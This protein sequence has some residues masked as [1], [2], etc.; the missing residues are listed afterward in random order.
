MPRFTTTV[1]G[2]VLN[3]PWLLLILSSS[4]GSICG[5][6][7]LLLGLRLIRGL[8][9]TI[10]GLIVMMK[11]LSQ[12][13]WDTSR[14]SAPRIDRA[15]KQKYVRCQLCQ[16][17]AP[18]SNV[19]L[20]PCLKLLSHHVID[21]IQVSEFV[22]LMAGTEKDTRV[23]DMERAREDIKRWGKLDRSER[24]DSYCHFSALRLC[25][26]CV[27][28]VYLWTCTCHRDVSPPWHHQ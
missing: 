22:K 10:L 16:P 23:N 12:D 26:P 19:L 18:C 1:V 3:V 7:W 9:R 20:L 5:L 13:I 28:S 27:P 11:D 21:R 15:S 17:T 8:Q 6:G 24:H 4:I 14:E 2:W 25:R